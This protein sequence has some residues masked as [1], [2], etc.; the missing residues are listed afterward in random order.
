MA[1]LLKDHG[2]NTACVGKWHLGMDMPT[3]DGRGVREAH[4]DVDKRSYHGD[5]DWRGTIENGPLSVGFDHFYGI[6]ASLD[7]HPYI[8]IDD[9]RFVGECTSEQDLLFVTRDYRPQRY[10]DNTGPSHKDFV[11]EDV[12][13]TITRKTV[14]YIEVQSPGTP[15]FMYMPL[16][17][18]HIPIVPSKEYRGRS[19]LALTA[20]SVFRLTIRWGGCSMRSIAKV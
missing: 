18:P 11:A 1:S 9:D 19:N 3:K 17:A 12:M 13:P 10:A 8:Y 4:A 14:E 6:S 7:M 15:F 20:T 5:I 2:Y 16:T